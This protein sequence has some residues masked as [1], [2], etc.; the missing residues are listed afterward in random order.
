MRDSSPLRIAVSPK[1]TATNE[2]V[3]QFSDA[4]E[5]CGA[6]VS[7]FVG[8]I[9]RRERYDVAIFHWPNRFLKPRST[10]RALSE[11]ARLWL[12]KLRGMRVVWVAHNKGV[13]DGAADSQL[14]PKLFIRSLDGVI[15]LSRASRQIITDAYPGT[16]GLPDLVIV[17]GRYRDATIPRA[18]VAPSEREPVVI[19]NVGLVRTYKN[20]EIL[21][22]TA[23]R[24]DA[25][26]IG[27]LLAGKR[28]DAD[29]AERLEASAA[30]LP[31]LRTDFRDEPVP[32]AEMEAMI[33][34]AHGV[35]LPYSDI[36]NSGSALQT[37]ARNRP[38]LTPAIGSM[39]ELAEMVGSTWVQLYDGAF[40]PEVL[41]GFLAHVR[42]I[43]DG[44]TVDLAQFEWDHIGER[45]HAFLR[46]L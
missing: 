37:L 14:V 27:L 11:L 22:D 18:F 12:A 40:T 21:L 1:R 23:K 45:I 16:R 24:L 15:H 29:L 25:D 3:E 34:G 43:P 32:Q 44:A 39:P 28:F 10:R 33:D 8:P 17:H 7:G 38:I 20:L 26:E 2:F 19:A 4:L 6:R 35:V 41:R 13:H 5:N 31:H 42:T 36:L 30:G 46:S 9:A